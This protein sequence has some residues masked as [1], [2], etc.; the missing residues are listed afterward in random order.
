MTQTSPASDGN[1]SE[2]CGV[3]R[4]DKLRIFVVDDHAVLRDGLKLLINSQ[5]DLCV[6]GEAAGGIAAVRMCA[7]QLPDVVVMD[8]SM[9]D[10]RG[11]EAAQQIKRQ[12]PKIHI[13]ALTRHADE[14]YLRRMFAAGATGYVL[15]R[16]AA[17]ELINAIRVVASGGTYIEPSLVNRVVG[18][19][20]SRTRSDN[21]VSP[22]R[23]LSQRE[24]QVLRALA[25]G[26]SNKEIAGDLAISVKTVEYHKS[27]G[28][29]KLGVRS[30]AEI[31][32]HAL[33]EG[34]LAGEDGLE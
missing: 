34:W 27:R 33:A 13:L 14:G 9:P 16:T 1:A 8:V 22:A 21:T 2:P 7:E 26:K 17:D 5:P 12:L 15:K 31:V 23:E 18:G 25:W 3:H 19:Y 6:V 28:A 10:L 30:R 20:A 4:G 11:F 24:A 29:E 32:R